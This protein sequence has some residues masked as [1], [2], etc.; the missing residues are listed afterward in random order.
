MIVNRTD[1]DA[2]CFTCG[3]VV[4]ATPPLLI[5]EPLRREPRRTFTTVH[6][7]ISN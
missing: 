3:N 2:A 7:S 5:T 6:S 1:G 4:Y